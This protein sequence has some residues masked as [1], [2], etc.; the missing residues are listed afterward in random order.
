MFKNL[1]TALVFTMTLS[2]CSHMEH[3]LTDIKSV[4]IDPAKELGITKNELKEQIEEA[5]KVG[6]KAPEFLA[7]D[8]FIKGND[9]SIRGDFQTAV[10]LFKF[11]NQ[12]QPKDLFVQKKLSIELIRMGELKEAEVILAKLYGTKDYK[13]ESVGLILAGVY[14]ALEK[15]SMA[16]DIYKKMITNYNSEE[17]CL[18]LAKAYSAE[19]KFSDAHSILATCEKKNPDEPS[20]AF[21]RG[22][23]DY[24][25]GKIA[26][27]KTYFMHSLKIDK[28][29]SQAAMALGAIYEDKEEYKQALNVYKKF[30]NEESNFQNIPILTKIVNVMLTMEENTEVLPYLE[31]LVSLETEDLNLK[32]RLGLLYSEIG[33]YEGALKLFN[34]VLEVVPESDKILYY[35]GALNH[36]MNRTDEA[37]EKY[38]KILPSSPLFGDANVQMAQIM[39]G[40]ARED[41]TMGKSE[42]IKAFHKFIAES[43]KSHEEL[44]LE[45]KMVE[46]G[47]Y[48]DTFK[49][50]EAINA[51]SPYKNAQ[52]FTDTHAYYLASLMEKTGQF[53]EARSIVQK[54]LDKDPNNPHA[55]NFLGY[56]FLERNENM[57]KAFEY[58]SKAVKIKPDD[59]YIRDSLAWYFYTV[60]KFPEALKE[61]K[62]AF[63]LN[64]SDVTITKHLAKIYESL[65]NFDK[66]REVYAEALKNSKVES[67]KEDVLNLINNLEKIRM[68]ASE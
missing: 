9:A 44:G 1:S 3:N 27:A 46:A 68:P 63:E 65:K 5:L 17:A 62:K 36:Q 31:N 2:A 6:G 18:Y 16:K 42:N 22:K 20:F 58:I 47:F 52:N 39:S 54:I 56:S 32:V 4:K 55:L 41:F 57:D 49:H 59:G 43:V 19:K 53:L 33:K 64:R 37:V 8:L 21:Y 11:V 60:G 40:K 30:L 45:L 10:S 26:T 7:S 29:F 15:N 48:D 24:E 51:L 67:E 38:A 13:D 14:T 25:A 34:D 66:A 61:A 23:I 35:L 12:L 28:T 50:A